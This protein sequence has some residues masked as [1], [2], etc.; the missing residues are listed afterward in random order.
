M[1]ITHAQLDSLTDLECILLS[2]LIERKNFSLI[3]QELKMDRYDV[4]FYVNIIFRKL[5]VFPRHISTLRMVWANSLINESF[6]REEHKKIR[7]LAELP[8][9]YRG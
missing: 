7:A 3:Q 6:N 9:L 5:D 4:S 1:L 8:V 2:K